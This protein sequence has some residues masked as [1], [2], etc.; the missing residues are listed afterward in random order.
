MV[1]A[2][3]NQSPMNAL[4]DVVKRFSTEAYVFCAE[5]WMK[6]IDK[7]KMTKK[8]QK[9]AIQR[10]ERYGVRNEPDKTEIFIAVCG[11]MSGHTHAEQYQI[12]RDKTKRIVDVVKDLKMSK[13]EMESTKTP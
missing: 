9:V 11:T 1:I 13:M 10:M 3:K 5:A 8:E 4:K 12:K 7:T 2:E 6:S